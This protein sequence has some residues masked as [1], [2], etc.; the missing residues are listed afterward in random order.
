MLYSAL[1][2]SELSTTGSCCRCFLG[3]Q[4]HRLLLLV[5]EVE[6]FSHF[7]NERVGFGG[8]EVEDGES[9]DAVVERRGEEDFF[10]VEVLLNLV[11]VVL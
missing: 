9:I 4:S 5:R 3:S 8:S 6:V 11:E 2:Y 1:A 10:V 7:L